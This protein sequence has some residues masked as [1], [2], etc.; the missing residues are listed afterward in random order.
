MRH[1]S[2]RGIFAQLDVRKGSGALRLVYRFINLFVEP[3]LLALAAV[4]N[5][6]L[7]EAHVSLEAPLMLVAQ[8]PEDI[9]Q[10]DLV[11][12]HGEL[13]LLGVPSYSHDHWM[14]QIQKR[15]NR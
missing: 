8:G 10:L 2:D 5:P 4:C 6:S 1:A 7:K 13:R 14:Y 3:P 15:L 12:L 11:D 9:C